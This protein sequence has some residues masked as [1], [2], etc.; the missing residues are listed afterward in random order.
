MHRYTYPEGKTRQLIID[1]KTGH[2]YGCTVYPED[3]FDTVKVA[4]LE[5]VNNYTVRGYRI[6]NG[7]TPEL[8]TFFYAEFSKTIESFELY[9]NGIH[10][11]VVNELTGRDVRLVIKFAEIDSDP[12]LSRVGIS[13]CSMKGAMQNLLAEIKTWELTQ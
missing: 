4:H 12:L 9:D 11:P 8:Y 6:S 5:V 7:W 10:N 2:E 13:P 1:L 3:D